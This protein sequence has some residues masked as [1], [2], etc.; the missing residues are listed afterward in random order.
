MGENQRMVSE[1][2]R[3]GS[4]SGRRE[5]STAPHA[6]GGPREGAEGWPWAVSWGSGPPHEGLRDGPGLGPG[7]QPITCQDLLD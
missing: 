1:K 5:R 3:E 7:A 4:L 2:P 6:A